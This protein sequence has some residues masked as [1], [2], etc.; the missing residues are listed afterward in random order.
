[1]EDIFALRIKDQDIVQTS[2]DE[3]DLDDYLEKG[4]QS[5]IFGNEKTVIYEKNPF[6]V[7]SLNKKQSIVK[8]A[9]SLKLE[10]NL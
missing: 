5:M 7:K 6:R 9:E 8:S 1:V 10:L 2:D 4:Y 3:S